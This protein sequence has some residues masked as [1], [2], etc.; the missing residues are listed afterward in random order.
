M[1]HPM[2]YAVTVVAALCWGASGVS[3]EYLMSRHGI[4]LTLISFV[5]MSIGGLL[6]LACVLLRSR[7][8]SAQHRD[9]VCAPR[10]WRDLAIYAVF[11]LAACQITY[12]GVIR[13]SNAGTG[14]IL[15]Y[16]GL[17]LIV[18]WVCLTHR[19]W[20]RACETIAIVLAVSGTFLLCTHGSLD[21]L[22]ITPSALAW[23]AVAALTLATYTLLPARL[24]AAYGADV[25]VGYALLIAGLGVGLVGRVWRFAITWTP[26]V[27]LAMVITV[28]LGTTVA[29]TAYLWGVDRIGPVK[30]SLIGSLEPIAAAALSALVM[31]TSYT[32]VDIVGMIL[33][34]GA[35]VTISVV[36]LLRARR[37][38]Q[39]GGAA[40]G[41]KRG[42]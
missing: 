28:V 12:M 8:V 34:V 6:T 40:V 16:L 39:E 7:G 2:G 5:R 3:A 23:G 10:N 29:F 27:I 22:V 42:S 9:L 24:I 20:P 13:A 30:A 15:E 11:G 17:I 25:V 18:V 1:R 31:G 14:T 21:S 19:R 32:G 38:T 37:V 35:V 41:L 33:I 4:E 36:D 26:D